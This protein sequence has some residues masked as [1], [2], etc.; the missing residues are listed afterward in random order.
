METKQ[1]SAGMK[2]RELI[3]IELKNGGTLHWEGKYM[4]I[5]D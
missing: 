3:F 4:K 1:N 2:T 5:K